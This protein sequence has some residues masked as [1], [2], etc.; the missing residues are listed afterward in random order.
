MVEE[1]ARHGARVTLV[2]RSKR[3]LEEVAARV[4]GFAFPLDLTDLASLDGALDRI[5]AAAGPIDV[6]INNAAVALVGDLADHSAQQ[7]AD[8]F[9]VNVVA[10]TELIRQAIPRMIGRGYGAIACVGSLAGH[11][12]VRGTALYGATKSGLMQLC[13]SLQRELRHTSVRVTVTVLGEV[14]DTEMMENG[15]AHPSIWAFSRRMARLRVLPDVTPEDVALALRI[16]IENGRNLVAVPRRTAVVSWIR[17]LPTRA[18]DLL[19]LG[20]D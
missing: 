18:N 6:L 11:A 7:V 15:R 19:S 5:E 17:E 2:A 8:S 14:A 10:P 4:D 3:V 20:I 1:F 16:G 12:S 9:A 13:T